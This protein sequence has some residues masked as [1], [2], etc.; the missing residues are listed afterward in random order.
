M[1]LA[2]L[3]KDHKVEVSVEDTVGAMKK[4]FV[5]ITE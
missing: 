1:N 3:W 4:G 2:G 5:W